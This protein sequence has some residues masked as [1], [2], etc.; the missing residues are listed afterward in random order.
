MWKS[1]GET[2]NVGIEEEVAM[3]GLREDGK[4][5]RNFDSSRQPGKMAPQEGL[6][7]PT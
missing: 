1:R 6:E 3:K 7:P 2:K 4:H 5:P